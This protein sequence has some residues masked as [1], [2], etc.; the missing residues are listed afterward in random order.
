MIC[1]VNTYYR[2]VRSQLSVPSVQSLQYLPALPQT[3]RD[4]LYKIPAAATI[5]NTY[6]VQ[7]ILTEA[8]SLKELTIL[9]VRKELAHKKSHC[10]E[11][12]PPELRE[13]H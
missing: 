11:E 2:N 13:I 10:P 5:G 6:K 9:T 1:L 8:A 4:S 3:S 12:K 7:E